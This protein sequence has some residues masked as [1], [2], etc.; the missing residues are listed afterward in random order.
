MK[1]EKASLFPLKRGRRDC[2]ELR[3]VAVFLLL[4]PVPMRMHPLI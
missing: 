3:L 2:T 1:A 4:G